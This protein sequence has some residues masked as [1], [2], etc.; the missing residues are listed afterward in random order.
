LCDYFVDNTRGG[1][2][3]LEH[4]GFKATQNRSFLRICRDLENAGISFSTSSSRDHLLYNLSFPKGDQ[5]A[6]NEAM[7]SLCETL[8][9][10]RFEE[11]EVKEDCLAQMKAQHSDHST[12][13]AHLLSGNHKYD[14]Y[15]I[16]R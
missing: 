7:R 16:V 6:L 2:W 12:D 10:P 5:R 15:M 11:W 9:C 13:M 3:L 4:L 14:H 1:T 8:V